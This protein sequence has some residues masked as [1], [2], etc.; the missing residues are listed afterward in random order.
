MGVPSN[1]GSLWV[2][3][4]ENGQLYGY[5]VNTDGFYESVEIL[6]PDSEPGKPPILVSAKDSDAPDILAALGHSGQSPETHGVPIFTQAGSIDIDTEGNVRLFSNFDQILNAGALPDSRILQSENGQLLFLSSPTT[7]YDHGVLGDAVEAESFTI[8]DIGE[9]EAAF[10]TFPVGN[11]QVVEGIS[12]IWTDWNGDGELEVIVTLSDFSNGGQIVVFDEQGN[13]LAEGPPIGLGYRWRHQIAVAPFGP[14]GE[15]ELVDVLTPHI[16]GV[17]EFYQWEEDTLR[18]VARVPGYTSHQIGSRNLDMGAAADFDGDGIV[19][20]I[21]PSQ[22]RTHLG[23]IQRVSGGA[24]VDWRLP[25]EGVLSSNLSVV[26]LTD[27]SLMLTAG[28]NDG[29]LRIWLP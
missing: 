8:V 23:A 1:D 13:R 15:M 9:E 6:P 3:A 5:F 22:D 14:S 21:L 17:V 20:V 24:E 7:A 2:A 18:I 11:G 26:Q 25:L 19:E 27:S 12:P 29:R 10:E 28:L 4:A 16:G